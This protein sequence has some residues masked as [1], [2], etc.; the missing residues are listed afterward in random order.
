MRLCFE[1]CF[2]F[3]VPLCHTVRGWISLI[4]R[5]RLSFSTRWTSPDHYGFFKALNQK[6][7]VSGH[8]L[9]HFWRLLISTV[10]HKNHHYDLG[11][12]TAKCWYLTVNFEKDVETN[13]FFAKSSIP[14]K[15]SQS[16]HLVTI[17]WTAS[18]GTPALPSPLSHG[19]SRLGLTYTECIFYDYSCMQNNPGGWKV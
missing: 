19:S 15:F 2:T 11:H 1:L 8:V 18:W 3:S 6:C 12:T 14:S 10:I 17:R 5:P 16:Q 13:W 7:I 9:T 4:L